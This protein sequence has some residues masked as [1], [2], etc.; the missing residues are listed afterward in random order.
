MLQAS[1]A[2]VVIVFQIRS[3][4][5]SLELKTTLVKKYNNELLILKFIGMVAALAVEVTRRQ[6]RRRNVIQQVILKRRH[7]ARI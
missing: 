5:L 3:V 7:D 2:A 4:L 1:N 6:N